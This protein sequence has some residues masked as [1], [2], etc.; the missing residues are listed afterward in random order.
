M[1]KAGEGGRGEV[2]SGERGLSGDREHI[3]CRQR[4]RK[5]YH[6]PKGEVQM[7]ILNT[8]MPLPKE[9][10]NKIANCKHTPVI[11]GH[12]HRRRVDPARRTHEWTSYED[13]LLPL[14]S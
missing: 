7:Q 9:K 4:K 2:G 6:H 10:M 14:F 11:R 3:V 1:G 8:L 5:P 13:S 12:R